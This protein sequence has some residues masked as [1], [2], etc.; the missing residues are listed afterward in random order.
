LEYLTP[1]EQISDPDVL[2]DY[3]AVLGPNATLA[4]PSA[5]AVRNQELTPAAL[6]WL[7]TNFF[8]TELEL[9][10]C[11]RLPAEGP[12]EC[13]LFLTCA[14]FITTPAYAPRLRRRHTTELQ[15]AAE[16]ASRGWARETERHQQT[17]R[18]IAALLAELGE[19]LQTDDQPEIP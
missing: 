17:A 19:P 2:A 8:R 12:C 5:T 1:P 6:D 18:H 13:D 14:K 11:L 15:L 10:H 16:A 3:Q 7:K 9:G 4:G